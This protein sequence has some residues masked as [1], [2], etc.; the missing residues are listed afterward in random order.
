[1]VGT[2]LCISKICYLSSHISGIASM[3]L[4]NCY[5]SLRPTNIPMIKFFRKIRQN[6]LNEGKTSKYFKYAI[7]EVVLVVI[8]ILIA[9]QINNLNEQVKINNQEKK[10]LNELINNM[11]ANIGTLKLMNRKQTDANSAIDTILNHF[12]NSTGSDSLKQLFPLTIYTETLNLSYST[13]E[14]IKTIGFDII[15][16]DQIRLSIIK[17]YEVK[18]SHQIKTIN[19]VSLIYFQSYL[20]WDLY[21]HEKR[22]RIFDSNRFRNDEKYH[23]IN[24]YV[25]QKRIWKTAIIRGNNQLIEKTIEVKKLIGAYLNNERLI[26]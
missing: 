10:L 12:Q 9:L 23:F 18:Y 15:K 6:L 3:M 22:D 4:S 7:G 1:M 24:N 16:N 2:A 26:E 5:P 20:E 25:N 19:E 8:G 14:T 21:N 17:L 13:F 11:D